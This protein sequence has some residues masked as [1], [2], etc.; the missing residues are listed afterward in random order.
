MDIVIECINWNAARYDRVSSSTLSIALL[1]EE[2]NEL[3][4][5]KDIIEV[6]D[7]CGDIIFVCCGAL[8]KL[9]FGAETIWSVLGNKIPPLE[10]VTFA[11]AQGNNDPRLAELIYL[12]NLS[13]LDYVDNALEHFGIGPLIG[14]ICEI[15]CKSN[16]TKSI[17]GKTDP[18]VKAN[19]NKGANYVPPTEDL[20]KLLC[21]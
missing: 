18:S 13:I 20:M 17:E 3:M 4:S 14:D 6:A 12:I 7:A 2:I 5:A 19:K 8:W 16:S 10:L 1:E 9:G 11:K 15:I 21:N